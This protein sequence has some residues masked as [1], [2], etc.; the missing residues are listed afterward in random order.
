M[1]S[2]ST[3]ESLLPST[4]P[5]LANH[6]V[7]RGIDYDNAHV[8][9]LMGR[10]LKELTDDEPTM[11]FADNLREASSA[12]PGGSGGS[13]SSSGSGG[14]GL[15]S[16][17]AGPADAR[18]EKTAAD[19]DPADFIPPHG[20][21]VGA[22]VDSVLVGAGGV[23][24]YTDGSGVLVGEIKRMFVD[25]SARGLG[26]GRRILEIAEDA[27]VTFGCRV[28]RLDTRTSLSAAR[29]LYVSTGYVEIQ[30][31]NDNKF[32]QHFYEKPLVL[33]E[34][35]LRR[36]G[37]FQ[38]ISPEDMPVGPLDM[39]RLIDLDGPFNF[40]DVGGYVGNGGQVVRGDLVFRSDKLDGLSDADLSLLA[41]LGITSV[42]DF[43]L[44]IERERHP[45]RFGLDWTPL[46]TVLSAS[47]TAEPDTS[48]VDL[49]TDVF[50]GR[51][52]LP[53]TT[54]WEESYASLLENAR[55]MFVT[56]FAGLANSAEPALYHCTGGKDRT[57]VATALL[58]RVLGVDDNTIVD[59]FL[60]TNLF[61]TAS[62]LAVL[63]RGLEANGT[64]T[65]ALAPI[66]GVTRSGILSALSELDTV[67]G[68]AEK[69]LLDG[70]LAASDLTALR[71]R[72]L[73][74]PQP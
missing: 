39:A 24:F 7:Y 35:A 30:R 71:T 21:F 48:M 66:A 22:F 36:F 57:G 32:A 49:L 19:A 14:S 27:A 6:V 54:F 3:S 37:A 56:L 69:Y 25:A 18:V 45:S 26:I 73:S 46:V 61:R 68:G 31:Y 8:Q 17:S 4:Q 41:G 38:G 52:P 23:R 58:L 28:A 59:D 50:A 67:Y 47:D 12:S 33:S 2:R 51:R 10:Y 60:L 65:A 43:R 29:A 42:Y 1:N 44:D 53:T 40:R 72:L 62:R 13:G 5:P 70:G 16:V 20:L 63:R 64:D 55:P 9:A 11:S 15:P 74:S 34:A